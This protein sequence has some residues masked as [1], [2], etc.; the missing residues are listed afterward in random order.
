MELDVHLVQKRELISDIWD[1]LY[2]KD[3][4]SFVAAKV[5]ANYPE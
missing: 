1:K 2:Y 5:V 4:K 3:G